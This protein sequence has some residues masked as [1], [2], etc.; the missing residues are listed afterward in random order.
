MAKTTGGFAMKPKDKKQLRTG[1]EYIAYE[2]RHQYR[3]GFRP[4]PSGAK[5]AW[6]NISIKVTSPTPTGS[7]QPAEWSVRSKGGYFRPAS[8]L[9]QLGPNSPPIR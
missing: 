8:S 7:K 4:T 3:I 2:L 1:W 6:S 5:E 9:D